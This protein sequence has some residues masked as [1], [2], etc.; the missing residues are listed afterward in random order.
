[1]ELRI[2]INNRR[3]QFAGIGR[4]DLCDF[5]YGVKYEFPYPVRDRQLESTRSG[6]TEE[7]SD[8]FVCLKPLHCAKYVVLHHGQCKTGNLSREVH[9][10]TLAEAEQLFAIVICHLG[11]PSHRVDTVCLE[12]AE[13]EVCCK[14]SVP[15]PVLA[16]FGEEQTDCGS[17][18]L[19]VNRAV[20]A[21]QSPVMLD[22]SFP[23]KALNNLVSLQVAPLSVILGLAQFDHPQQMTFDVTAGN[24]ANEVSTGKPAV[25]Q[26]IV[27]TDT[28]FDGILHHL[29]GL[30]DL[31]HR[32]LLGALFN[33]LSRIVG[34]KTLT[35]LLVRQSLLLVWLTAFFTMKREIEKQLTY[36]VAQ[37]QC[38][39]L[40]AEDALM[41]DMGEYLADELT[42]A[43]A[44]GS[45]SVIDNQADRLVMWCLCITAN[46][47]QQL[48]VHR[49]Q[50]LTPFDISIS[51]KTIE[52]VLLTT[53]QAA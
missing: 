4:D 11:S 33:A 15:L 24:K 43:S 50:Q 38:K 14:Q 35:A 39:T 37:K 6:L 17:C 8:S 22:L 26:Q 40:V 27:E 44:L 29:N 30:V 28:A 48:D 19:D 10:L 7:S 46:L 41:L 42:L 1:M 32:V 12:E 13:R 25:N 3:K 52:H 51:H 21:L 49:I 9:T 23:M 45:V 5:Q 18:K 16:S 34:S 31:R 47:T 2:D 53:E 36:A 20:R